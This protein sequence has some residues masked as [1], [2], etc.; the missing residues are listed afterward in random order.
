MTEFTPAQI[1]KRIYFIR[2]LRV[3]LDVDLANLYGVKTGALNRAVRRNQVRFPSDFMFQL[4]EN[5]EEILRCQIGISKIKKET[6][7]GR[8]YLPLVFTEQ[9]VAMLS[10]VLRSENAAL[11]NIEIMRTFVKIREMLL[12]NQNLARKLSD[13]EKKYDSQF[14]SVF[15]AIRQ[16]M[17]P[18]DTPRRRIGII[19]ED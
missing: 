9:G 18:P 14:A 3:M 2:G 11:V 13:L 1:S 17:T 6:R 15:D 10:S 12:S 7:G 19:N 8:Q 5:E 4:S 16:L